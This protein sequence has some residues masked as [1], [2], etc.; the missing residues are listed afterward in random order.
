MVRPS[1]YVAVVRMLHTSE[2]M[3]M[4]LSCNDYVGIISAPLLTIQE[5]SQG[6]Q[7]PH[8]TDN[9]LIKK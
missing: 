6:K 9:N 7:I 1:S 3:L 5:G 4:L 8:R 2:R